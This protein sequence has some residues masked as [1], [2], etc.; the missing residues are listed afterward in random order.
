[1]ILALSDLTDEEI[2]ATLPP[3][4]PRNWPVDDSARVASERDRIARKEAAEQEEA[5]KATEALP[6]EPGRRLEYAAT[7]GSWMSL[8]VSPDGTQLVFDLLGDLYTLPVAG[9]EA[10]PLTTGMA[11]D[12][13]PRYSPDGRWVAF[14][15]DRDGAENL[16]VLPHASEEGEDAEPRKLEKARDAGADTLLL[17]LEDS[18][19]LQQ[20]AAARGNVVD[21]VRA[22]GFG[23]TE[24]AV[25]SRSRSA[26]LRALRKAES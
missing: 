16:W 10:L 26:K 21:L 22:G 20:K 11:F 3:P 5:K 17:D 9:G 12:S 23:D 8:D 19:A 15:S 14:L 25:N 4:G 18:V 2:L 7:E 24:V 13:Q 6:L 1:M